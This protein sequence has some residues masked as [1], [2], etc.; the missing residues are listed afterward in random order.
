MVDEYEKAVKALAQYVGQSVD[1][2]KEQ[3]PDVARE[4]LLY[5]A[6][7]NQVVMV[8]CTVV[9]LI[10]LAYFFIGLV[11]REGFA[12]GL[13]LLIGGLAVVT[14]ASAWVD[15]Y[16]IEHAPKLYILDDLQ[17]KVRNCD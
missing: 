4:I 8:V 17:R 2:A 11:T 12:Q 10:S 14:F 16:K 9:I 13:A 5:A 7:G 15:N 3:A 6:Y 1:F